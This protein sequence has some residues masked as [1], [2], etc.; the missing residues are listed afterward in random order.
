M[1][2]APHNP[3]F[4]AAADLN[5]KR[6]RIFHN[7]EEQRAKGKDVGPPCNDGDYS[8]DGFLAFAGAETYMDALTQFI[9]GLKLPS[10]PGKCAS[11]KLIELMGTLR[12]TVLT[13]IESLP[14]H[15][16]TYDYAHD[17]RF[18]RHRKDTHGD[19]LSGEE[20]YDDAKKEFY[21][22]QKI[23]HWTGAGR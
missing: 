11:L 6:R 2:S 21:R 15:T 5:L 17:K 16:V 10:R 12:P 18:D 7:C 23:G 20:M 13:Q 1:L 8:P 19:L 9:F 22:D 3:L 14:L 4:K